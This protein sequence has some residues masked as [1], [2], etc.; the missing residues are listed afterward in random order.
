MSATPIAGINGPVDIRGPPPLSSCIVSMNSAQAVSGPAP[1]LPPGLVP[2]PLVQEELKWLLLETIYAAFL[3]PIAVVLFFFST[4]QL[5][6]RPIFFLNVCALAL[7]IGQGIIGI[8]NSV[9]AF[10]PSTSRHSNTHIVNTGQRAT[11]KPI[12]HPECSYRLRLLIH[13]RP[14]LRPRNTHTSGHR[15]ISTEDLALS[16][17]LRRLWAHCALQAGAYSE[18]GVHDL[19]PPATC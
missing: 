17:S 7:G 10:S 13:G 9:R 19:P 1:S 15:R 12:G 6:R 4:P 2:L 16:P 14:T 18:C 8:S 3:V 11:L 5:R